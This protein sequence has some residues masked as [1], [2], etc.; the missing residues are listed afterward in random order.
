MHNRFLQRAHNFLFRR[1]QL[2]KLLLERQQLQL[3]ILQKFGLVTQ[4]VFKNS[5]GN[6]LFRHLVDGISP[7]LVSSPFFR[8]LGCKEKNF[9]DDLFFNVT[10]IQQAAKAID[11]VFVRYSPVESYVDQ[12]EMKPVLV[13]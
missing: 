11:L 10:G 7:A 5:E 3:T 2:R 13:I 12:K 8:R 6:G 9:S 4:L 1:A